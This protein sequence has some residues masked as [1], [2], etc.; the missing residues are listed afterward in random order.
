M[1]T[2]IYDAYEY[3]GTIH[4][5]MKDLFKLR[6]QWE[7]KSIKYLD[8]IYGASLRNKTISASKFRE[9]CEDCK[10]TNE[11]N[12]LNIDVSAM[13]YFYKERIFVKFFGQGPIFLN[14]PKSRFTDFSYWDNTDGP[15]DMSYAEFSKRGKIWDKI[16]PGTFSYTGLSFDFN[17]QNYY[18][19]IQYKFFQSVWKTEN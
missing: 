19:S 3:H 5:L 9:D 12:P 10:R 2:R 4:E 13:I 8:E 1:S 6:K 11:R 17:G 15:E 16:V 14:I 7:D 18:D